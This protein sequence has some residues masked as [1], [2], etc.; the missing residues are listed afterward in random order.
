MGPSLITNQVH[1]LRVGELYIPNIIIPESITP[2]TVT[3]KT[4]KLGSF[5]DVNAFVPRNKLNGY[6]V[7]PTVP[8]FELQTNR[9]GETID[10]GPNNIPT[11]EEKKKKQQ[12][13]YTIQTNGCQMNVADS[14]R[15]EGI[16][17]KELGL[18]SHSCW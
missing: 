3:N 6:G 15:L 17:W 18:V 11:Q 13:R 1:L 12:R 2:S 14:E 16:L 7:M 8:N 5:N 9:K 10:N 4:I